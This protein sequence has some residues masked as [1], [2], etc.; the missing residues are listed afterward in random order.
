MILLQT[1]LLQRLTEGVKPHL[2]LL[3]LLLPL[4][5]ITSGSGSV[6]LFTFER[7]E[8]VCFLAG[9]SHF[10]SHYERDGSRLPE[11]NK[12]GLTAARERRRNWE[13]E[14]ETDREPVKREHACRGNDSGAV[15]SEVFFFLPYYCGWLP[16]GRSLGRTEQ[17]LEQ[18][19]VGPL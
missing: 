16:L 19:K 6:T 1:Y 17:R 11:V 2:L 15:R 5:L 7:L 3:L 18:L 4:L 14:G 10:Q 12:A 9:F 8:S 13:R